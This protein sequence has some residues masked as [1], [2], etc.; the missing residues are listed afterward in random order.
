ML[1]R[2]STHGAIVPRVLFTDW[3]VAEA[4]AAEALETP[5]AG[6]RPRPAREGISF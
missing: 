3:I 6:F 4:R 1:S 2:Y 5:A